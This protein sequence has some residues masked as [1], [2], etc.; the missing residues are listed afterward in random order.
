MFPINRTPELQARFD[1]KRQNNLPLPESFLP[2]PDDHIVCQHGNKFD[3]EKIVK[4]SDT[5]TIFEEKEE[6]NLYKRV[7]AA[8][9]LGECKVKLIKLIHF[10]QS[11]VFPSN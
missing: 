3:P 11:N 9:S 8:R 1:A 7:F 10:E 4:I 5:V 6:Y 2:K